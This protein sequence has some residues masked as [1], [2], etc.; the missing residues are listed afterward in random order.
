MV[1]ERLVV[2]RGEYNK[3][4]LMMVILVKYDEGCL[5]KV[6]IEVVESEKI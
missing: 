2:E 3:M 6:E 5:D 4:V 1:D